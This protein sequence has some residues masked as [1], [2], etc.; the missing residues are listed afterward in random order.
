MMRDHLSNRLMSALPE[1]DRQRCLAAGEIVNLAFG[2]VLAEPGQR[3][4][5]VYFP[6]ASFISLTTPIQPGVPGARLE[7]GMIGDEGM[8]GVS[9]ILGI[10]ISPLHAVVQGGG[11]VLRIAILPFRHQLALSAA[12]RRQIKRY[13]FVLIQQLAQSAACTRYHLVEERLARWLLM[14][15]DRA[16]SAE[17]H[18]THEF[19]AYMLGVRRVGVTKAARALQQEGLI[20]YRRGDIHIINRV[21]LEQRACV[22]YEAAKKS[23]ARIL[24]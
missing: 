19:L 8:L 21:G 3:I 11:P 12:L 7:V 17:F 18:L 16:H 2:E 23:Y 6:M 9:V 22:C 15:Q 13:L 14:S 4:R 1:L 5:Y 20:Q 10:P 24:G